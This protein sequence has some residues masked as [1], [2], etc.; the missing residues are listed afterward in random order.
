MTN[1]NGRF[2]GREQEVEEA[3]LTRT[4]PRAEGVSPEEAESL[5]FRGRPRGAGRSGV[6][7]PSSKTG[8]SLSKETVSI[9]GPSWILKNL[10]PLSKTL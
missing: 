10:P 5:T 6:M 8:L 7:N 9:R 3:W 4:G 2:K 1:R